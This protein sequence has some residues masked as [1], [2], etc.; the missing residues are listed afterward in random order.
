MRGRHQSLILAAMALATGVAIAW[1][2]TRPGWD[3]TG[4]TAGAL[5]LAAG[6]V[7][8]L[9]LRWWWAALLVALPI[10]VAEFRGGGLV[11]LAVS[12]F[13][14]AGATLGALAGRISLHSRQK[15]H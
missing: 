8:F 11:L 3:D 15:P 6:V 4:V 10:L 1:V 9:G 13:T 2:D 14:I 12:M 7:A 5:L